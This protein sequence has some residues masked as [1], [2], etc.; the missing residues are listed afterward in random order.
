[1]MLF[2]YPVMNS[3]K[4]IATTNILYLIAFL[5]W[6]IATFRDPGYLKKSDKIEFLTLVERFEPGWLWPKCHVIRTPRSRHCNIC[7][8]WVERFDHH[9]PWIDNCIGTRNH[10][11]F[12]MFLIVTYVMLICLVLQLSLNFSAVIYYSSTDDDNRYIGFLL[13][14]S[15]VTNKV[16]YKGIWT[17]LLLVGTFFWLLMNIL[18]FT[19]IINFLSN[20]TMNERYG[21]RSKK[22]VDLNGSERSFLENDGQAALLRNASIDSTLEPNKNSKLYNFCIMMK[23][24]Q[25]KDQYKLF[26]E[27]MKRAGS[28]L[29][30]SVL[31][32][33]QFY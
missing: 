26:M 6:A 16:V 22:P 7:D 30:E 27:S 4:W 15:L 29:F 10:G 2:I 20:Q 14:R 25:T 1:M 21:A 18:L 5:L 12:L 8:K 19:Q 32:D 28:S 33:K 23:G 31:N 24:S 3:L 9:W 13:P 17:L 11:A